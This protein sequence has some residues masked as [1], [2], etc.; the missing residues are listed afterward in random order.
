MTEDFATY[1]AVMKIARRECDTCAR[2]GHTSQVCPMPKIDINTCLSNPSRPFWRPKSGAPCGICKNDDGHDIKKCVECNGENSNFEP[3]SD[4]YVRAAN[5]IEQEQRQDEPGKKYDHGKPRYDLLPPDVLAEVVKIFTDGA[6]K[7]GER[8]W[9]AGMSWSRP[10]AA[11]MRHLWAF[12]DRQN[13][14]PES[15]SP[16]LAHAIVNL[17]FLM[18]YQGRDVGTDDR[19]IK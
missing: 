12:W 11:A 2:C 17:I 4:M 5:I 3:I 9:E 16:H 18:D 6:E 10:F 1:D 19:R 7:Y 8:N 13:I 15:G 14:D